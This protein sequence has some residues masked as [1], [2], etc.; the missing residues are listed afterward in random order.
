MLEL[1]IAADAPRGKHESSETGEAALA[2][3][4]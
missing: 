4:P 1:A 2:K 3:S